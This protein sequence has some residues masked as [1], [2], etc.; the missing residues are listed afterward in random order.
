[1]PE[2][3][4]GFCLQ[5]RCEVDLAVIETALVDVYESAG[6][7]LATTANLSKARRKK[8]IRRVVEY[9]PFLP[10]LCR[11]FEEGHFEQ[12]QPSSFS[13]QT[14]FHVQRE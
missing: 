3:W 2:T 9:G 1:M 6:F 10:T 12:L 7:E 4:C 14:K 11:P 13:P 8:K 5:W